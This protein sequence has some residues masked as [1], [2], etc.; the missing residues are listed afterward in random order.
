[1]S[2]KGIVAVAH[3]VLGFLQNQRGKAPRHKRY[4]YDW[5]DIN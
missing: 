2:A 3:V 1:M 4:V 5:D